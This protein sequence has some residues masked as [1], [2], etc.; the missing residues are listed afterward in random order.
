MQ[1][2]SLDGNLID[3]LKIHSFPKITRLY[4]ST[5]IGDELQQSQKNCPE[6]KVYARTLVT[7]FIEA[8]KCN[9]TKTQTRFPEDKVHAHC[10]HRRI[11]VNGGMES[12]FG[13]CIYLWRY[14]C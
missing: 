14:A 12:M 11:P 9:K 4:T 8:N 6:F 10:V 1:K 2:S 13:Y 7:H 3:P 5:H